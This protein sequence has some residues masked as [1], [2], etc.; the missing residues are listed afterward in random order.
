[1]LTAKSTTY[2]FSLEEVKKAIAKEINVIPEKMTIQAIT[3]ERGD[4]R[5]GP[6]SKE[7]TGI[8]VTVKS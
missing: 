6:T 8:R 1:M 5:F 3:E 2:E 4:E 7:V